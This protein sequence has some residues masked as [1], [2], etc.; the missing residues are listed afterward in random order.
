MA[1]TANKYKNVR[2][3]LCWNKTSA[4]LARSHNNAQ[5]LCLGARLLE[6]ETVFE[7]VETFLTTS[8]EAGRHLKRIKKL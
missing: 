4:E 1:M 2:A 6:L 3:A 5:V 8:F 7:I